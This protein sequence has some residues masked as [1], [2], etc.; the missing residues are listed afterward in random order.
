M[1]RWDGI[2]AYG[3]PGN[4]GECGKGYGCP[5]MKNDGSKGVPDSMDVVMNGPGTN[6]STPGMG[7]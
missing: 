7:R 1:Y 4:P 3:L 5:G 6:L 2:G